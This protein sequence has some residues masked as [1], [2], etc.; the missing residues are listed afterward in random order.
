MCCLSWVRSTFTSSG[1]LRFMYGVRYV[2]SVLI[3]TDAHVINIWRDVAGSHAVLFPFCRLSWTG[4]PA[5]KS[6]NLCSIITQI[7]S[8]PT[9][10]NFSCISC[11]DREASN[12]HRMGHGFKEGHKWGW[13]CALNRG[14]LGSVSDDPHRHVMN[15]KLEIW[16][17]RPNYFTAAVSV[18]RQV[19]TGERGWH[20]PGA[21]ILTCELESNGGDKWG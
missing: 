17:Q 15:R 9:V 10:N 14:W 2:V 5:W 6:R 18:H 11:F 8:R 21:N 4:L 13:G 12:C 3:K 19:A 7:K 1:V 16:P 20:I